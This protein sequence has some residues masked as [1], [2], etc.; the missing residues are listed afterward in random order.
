MGTFAKK[1]ADINKD[2][3]QECG[4]KAAHLGELTCMNLNVPRGFCVV[5]EAFLTHLERNHL[6]EKISEIARGIDYE[7]YQSLDQKTAEI[8]SLIETAG[9]PREI[10]EEIVENYHRL[11]ES[12]KEPFVAVR[13]SVAVKGSTITSFPGMMDTFHYIQGAEAVSAYVKRCWASVWSARGASLRQ[14]RGI[15]HSQ[16]LIAPIIQK[17]VNAR[18]AGVMFTLNP[19]NGDPS[20]VVI[21]GG[22]G[23]GESVV[24]GSLTPDQFIVDKVILEI[25]QRA[26]YAKKVEYVYSP[27]QRKV[28]YQEVT[29][30]RQNKSC[31]EDK[32]IIELVKTARVIEDHYGRHQDIEWAID[33]DYVFPQNIFILQSRAETIWNQR[34]KEPIIGEK[35]GYELLLERAMKTTKI[36]Y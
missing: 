30:E 33:D 17:M 32:E 23:V 3:T 16:A 27:A 36:K 28:V 7:D 15:E 29:P 26:I 19:V 1:F 35:S 5:A 2:M 22:W 31:L 10:E 11:L 25:S 4:G 12:E 13:S 20:K 9:M 6:Q 14:K 18:S 21:E 34:L 24:S 8:R